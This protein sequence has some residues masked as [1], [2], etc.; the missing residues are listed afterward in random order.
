M[1]RA[2]VEAEPHAGEGEKT[3]TQTVWTT[4]P[5]V[6]EDEIPL[7]TSASPIFGVCCGTAIPGPAESLDADDT[8]TQTIADEFEALSKRVKALEA[9]IRD[10]RF[11]VA[12]LIG[13]AKAPQVQDRVSDGQDV[14]PDAADPHASTFVGESAPDPDMLGPFM[15]TKSGASAS[16][17]YYEEVNSF[18]SS[19]GRR[20][21]WPNP[22]DFT[23]TPAARSPPTP[24]IPGSWNDN[25]VG[26]ASDKSQPQ[27]L[28]IRGHPPGTLDR[29]PAT[30]AGPGPTASSTTCDSCDTETSSS[31]KKHG[32]SVA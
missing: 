15:R 12:E 10:M 7:F 3:P 8:R 23:T 19:L 18:P 14:A 29:A 21:V 28:P 30:R 16:E 6:H 26:K 13:R 32:Y 27:P 2:A 11:V 4:N 17:L 24:S 1:P 22:D 9:E 5:G 20:H 25:A 31:F